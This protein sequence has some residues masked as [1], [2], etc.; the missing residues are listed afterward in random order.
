MVYLNDVTIEDGPL[1]IT[2]V[3]PNI[4]EN[5]RKELKPDYKKRQENE[6]KNLNIKDYSPLIGKF[7]TTIFFDTNAPHFAGKIHNENSMRKIIRF[8]FRVKPENYFKKIVKK[9]LKINL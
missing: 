4:Y 5:F 1:F 2:K 3:D 7:G 8:N 9:I 6:V